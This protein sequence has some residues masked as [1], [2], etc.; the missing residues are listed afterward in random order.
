MKRSVTAASFVAVVCAMT[1]SAP[2]AVAST[3]VTT[4]DGTIAGAQFRA[5]VPAAWNGTLVLWSHAAYRFGFEPSDVELTNHPATRQWLLDH[6]YAIAASKYSPVSGWQVEAALRDQL[7]L[8][9]WFDTTVG[10]PRHTIAEGA[11]MGGMV[12]TLLAERYP[13]RVDGAAALCADNVGSV[14]DW[15][16]G[17]DLSY[18]VKTLLDTDGSLQLTHITDPPANRAAAI[19]I[20]R[21]SMATAAGRARLA[22]AAAVADVAAWSTPGTPPPT[23]LAGQ[24]AEQSGYYGIM[25][26]FFL[27]GDRT[28]M[29][30]TAGGNPSW[31][32]GVDYNQL[33]NWS[34]Q[35]D[36]ARQAYQAAGLDLDADMARLAAGPRITPD[37]AALLYEARFGTPTGALRVP[38]VTMHT[39]GD[40]LTPP[41]EEH[42]Y[43]D[44]VTWNHKEAN[45]RQ[46]WTARAGHCT[47]TAAEEITV[48][49]A[50]FDRVGTGAWP[51]TD[52][53]VLTALAAGFPADHHTV[54]LSNGTYTAVS[55]AFTAFTPTPYL[56]PFPS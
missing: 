54:H 31:N 51:S 14:A 37:P 33:L 11:S 15:N 24:L 41:A 35:G 32:I 4:Y 47:I 22:L 2:A 8:L 46:L 16:A 40:G 36:L 53:A 10:V 50:I 25:L 43:A 39:T 42:L 28:G 18:V 29:E 5:E 56:R 55:S 7:A 45:L 49:Q 23:D 20:I 9:D 17:L 6:G 48:L 30:H 13:G 19:A 34:P 12:T 44:R 3:D 52:P 27:G 38:L 1:F 21:S 26:G